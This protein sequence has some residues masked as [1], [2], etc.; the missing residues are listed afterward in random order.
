MSISSQ[1]MSFTA[2]LEARL[3]LGGLVARTPLRTSAY[4]TALTGTPVRLKCEHH[5]ETGSF[6]LRG[7]TNAM[8]ALDAAQRQ[9]GIAAASTGNHGRAL[10]F[11]ARRAGI[12]AVICMSGL[13][14]AN[15]I[16]A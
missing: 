11:A 1:G 9:A 14:P 6:K 3:R 2:I 16:K 8:L 12:R 13:V 4:L 10:A 7:A 15:K 5:Q